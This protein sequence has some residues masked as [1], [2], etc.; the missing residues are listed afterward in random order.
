MKKPDMSKIIALLEKGDNFS[1]N[2]SQY[3]RMIFQK[4]NLIQKKNQPFPKEQKNM[5]IQ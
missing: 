3:Q 4:V 5:G 2:R 1:L